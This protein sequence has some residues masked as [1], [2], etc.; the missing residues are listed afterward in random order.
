[1]TSG[2]TD[3]RWEWRLGL[4]QAIRMLL[5]EV[6]TLDFEHRAFP[7]LHLQG[8]SQRN[9]QRQQ[10]SENTRL[11]TSKFDPPMLLF[12]PLRHLLCTK[13]CTNAQCNRRESV[14]IRTTQKVEALLQL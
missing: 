12:L 8:Q 14:P 11:L 13:P 10:K 5:A 7:L 9:S 6:D 3:S 4:P 2:E 1:M